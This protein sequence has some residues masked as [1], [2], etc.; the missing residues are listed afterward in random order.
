MGVS[1]WLE[2]GGFLGG[3]EATGGSIFGVMGLFCM[4]VVQLV[5]EISFTSVVHSMSLE[6]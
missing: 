2:W 5:T 4:F 3:G 1:F 6:L